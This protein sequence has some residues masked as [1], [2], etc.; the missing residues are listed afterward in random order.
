[1]MSTY[2]HKTESVRKDKVL[3]FNEAEC[4]VLRTAYGSDLT[5]AKLREILLDNAQVRILEKTF[6]LPDPMA[7]PGDP[8][9]GQF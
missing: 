4:Q 5:M 7:S 3:C 6:A 8:V 1:M 9:M 2:E